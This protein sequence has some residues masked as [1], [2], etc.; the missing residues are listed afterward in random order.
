MG[1][2]TRGELA[3]T[4]DLGDLTAWCVADNRLVFYAPDND[5]AWLAADYPITLREWA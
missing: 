5:R 1:I 3:W 4:F 2:S